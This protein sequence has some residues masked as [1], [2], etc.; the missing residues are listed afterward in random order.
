MSGE[1]TQEQAARNPR[2]E[3]PGGS[4]KFLLPCA[5]NA[6]SGS[7][8]FASNPM[9]A[10]SKQ[11]DSVLQQGKYAQTVGPMYHPALLNKQLEIP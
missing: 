6:A 9:F 11:R 10:L 5:G 2:R 7:I 8:H 1:W 3:K 4:P